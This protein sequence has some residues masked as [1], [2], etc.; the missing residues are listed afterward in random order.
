[1]ANAFLNAWVVVSI[2]EGW[3]FY[4]AIGDKGGAKLT[5]F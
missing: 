2:P 4:L 5:A 3:P 1:M